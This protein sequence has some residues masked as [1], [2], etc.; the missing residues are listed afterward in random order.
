MVT[1]PRPGRRRRIRPEDRA[2][3]PAAI[4]PAAGHPAGA[5]ISRAAERPV[6]AGRPAAGATPPGRAATTRGPGATCPTPA[7]TLRGRTGSSSSSTK[8]PR[9]VPSPYRTSSAATGARLK[10]G[11]PP[12][13]AQLGQERDPDEKGGHDKKEDTRRQLHPARV[14]R[15][16]RRISATKGAWTRSTSA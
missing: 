9:Q 6:A 16:P 3:R 15:G 8:T 4:R 13:A 7:A 14:G 12:A 10:A 5:A 2:G 1:T 11:R